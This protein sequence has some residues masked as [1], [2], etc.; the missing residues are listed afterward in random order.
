MNF[1]VIFKIRST[2]KI[3]DLFYYFYANEKKKKLSENKIV[4][5]F[6]LPY[7]PKKATPFPIIL[8]S[9]YFIVLQVSSSFFELITLLERGERNGKSS[10]SDKLFKRLPFL[11]LISESKHKILKLNLKTS[12]TK[13][14]N[15]FFHFV[16]YNF[17]FQQE[18]HHT[19]LLLFLF[20]PTEKF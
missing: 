18:K 7:G 17:I 15:Y 19:S 3:L 5:P 2:V 9:M 20:F 1:L 10:H 8:S 12:Y 11:R 16:I 4:L 13:F 6:L 14:L